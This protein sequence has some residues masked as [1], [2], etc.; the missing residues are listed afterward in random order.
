MAR[1]LRILFVT[2]VSPFPP[3]VGGNQRSNLLLRA[4][5]EL[6]EVDFFLYT[7]DDLHEQIPTL[8]KDFGL[9]EKID[10]DLAGRIFPFSLVYPFAPKLVQNIAGTLLPRTLD[11]RPVPAVARRIRQYMAERNYDLVVGR[12]L[13]ATTKIGCL[14]TTPALLDI[15]DIDSHVY[16][17]RLKQPG[18]SF[19]RRMA[20]LWQ[21]LQVGWLLPSRLKL[22]NRIFVCQNDEAIVGEIPNRVYLPNIPYYLPAAPSSPQPADA[23]TILFVGSFFHLP[24]E[25]A[26]DFFVEKVWPQLHARNSELRFK[27]VGSNLQPHLRERWQKHPGVDAVGFVEDLSESYRECLFS[28]VPLQSV[29]GTNIKILEALAHERACVVTPAS[30]AGYAGHLRHEDS[31]MVASSPEEFAAACQRLIDDP[32]LRTAMGK[33]GRQIVTEEFSYARFSRTVRE[34]VEECLTLG[35]PK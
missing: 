31:I 23:K 16:R 14:G 32:A 26:V 8:K 22:F 9:V 18:M 25:P 20:N 6:G 28:I 1:S 21:S 4:L 13:L 29:T 35:T 5:R 19:P 24:N 2:S 3:T 34:T 17:E 30:Q 27:I 10:W 11:Y 33:K 12:Y 7:R 15:D